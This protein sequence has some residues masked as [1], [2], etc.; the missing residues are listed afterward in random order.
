MVHRE[1]GA[2][3]RAGSLCGPEQPSLL[4]SW[5]RCPQ[6]FGDRSSWVHTAQPTW[7]GSAPRP[8]LGH[9]QVSMGQIQ[10]VWVLLHHAACQPWSG[11]WWPSSTVGSITSPTAQNPRLGLL[12]FF[13]LLFSLPPQTQ[14]PTLTLLGI[15]SAF[16]MA[17]SKAASFEPLVVTAP[18][19]SALD[20]LFKRHFRMLIFFYF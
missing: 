8:H 10:R 3:C 11:F 1:G 12:L 16:E 5:C 17:V 20:L 7:A 13:L 9:I 2:L 18:I 14:L 19:P 15:T 6:A 4:S